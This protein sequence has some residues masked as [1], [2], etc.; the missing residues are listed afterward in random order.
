[1]AELC[2]IEAAKRRE[3]GK[4]IE[5]T[6]APIGAKVPEKGRAAEGGAVM[7]PVTANGRFRLSR[8]RCYH[9]G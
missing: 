1:M 6:S 7:S 2:A 5:D 3:A 4:K 8:P 9:T